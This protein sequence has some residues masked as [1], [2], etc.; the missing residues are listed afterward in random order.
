MHKRSSRLVSMAFISLLA[1]SSLALAACGNNNDDEPDRQA[2]SEP[3]QAWEDGFGVTRE[4]E[5]Y[6]GIE[7]KFI[8]RFQLPESKIK[9]DGSGETISLSFAAAGTD[10]WEDQY[11]D[12][13]YFRGKGGTERPLDIPYNQYGLWRSHGSSGAILF[14]AGP[15]GTRNRRTYKTELTWPLN[16][17]E[18][19][20][21]NPAAGWPRIEFNTRSR[22]LADINSGTTYTTFSVGRS[23]DFENA[24]PDLC[25]IWVR[26]T[27]LKDSADFIRFTF[28][29]FY[30]PVPRK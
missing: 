11:G 3:T 14:E 16:K 25:A 17:A 27:R 4:N 8:N 5:N 2:S 22:C 10:V 6:R 1:V 26:V 24:N 29:V 28:E 9:E 15:E 21:I 18:F 19:A 30:N 12:L 7:V 13:K 23:Y 20:F